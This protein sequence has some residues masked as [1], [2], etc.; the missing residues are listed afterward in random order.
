MEESVFPAHA[1]PG[2]P[3]AEYFERFPKDRYQTEVESWRHLQSDNIEF[4]MKR[5][6]EPVGDGAGLRT[7]D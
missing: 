1:S 2:D 7:R 6:R 5:L 3:A 4:V